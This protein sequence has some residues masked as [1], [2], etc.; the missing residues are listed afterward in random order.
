[1]RHPS[2]NDPEKG[3]NQLDFEA[4]MELQ[5]EERGMTGFHASID[6]SYPKEE[7]YADLL[8][9]MEAQDNGETVPFTD[10]T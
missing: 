4:Y 3:P 2:W 5:K 6:K 7:V 8:R 10:D 1:M 9:M